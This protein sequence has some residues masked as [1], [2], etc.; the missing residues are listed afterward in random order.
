M[1]VVLDAAAL[2]AALLDEE[3]AERVRPE[4]AEARIS[5]VNLSEAIAKL[6]EYRVS[7]RE[8]RAQVERLELTIHDF[9]VADAESTALLRAHTKPFGLSLGDRACIALGQRLA[10]P[11][12]TSDRRMA[13]AAVDLGLDIRLIR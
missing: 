2:L 11:I 7:V 9:T 3:G 13:S 1:A 5:S 6:L 8:V 10:I 4:L 12:L